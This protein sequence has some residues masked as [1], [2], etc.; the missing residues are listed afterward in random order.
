MEEFCT[1]AA[2]HIIYAMM[3][4]VLKSMQSIQ[5]ANAQPVP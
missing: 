1:L 2:L 4:L 5:I 3:K